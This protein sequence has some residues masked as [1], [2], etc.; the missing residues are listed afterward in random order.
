GVAQDAGAD[1]DVDSSRTGPEAGGSPPLLGAPAASDA[2]GPSP[3][4]V[5]TPPGASD[6]AASACDGARSC[7]TIAN[8]VQSCV[9]GACV[10]QCDPGRAWLNGECVPMR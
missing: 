7:P 10:V 5:T 3:P 4:A 8:G 9:G 6:A 1:G 2:S